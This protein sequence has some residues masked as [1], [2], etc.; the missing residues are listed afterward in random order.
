MFWAVWGAWGAMLFALLACIVIY[1]VELP[2]LDDWEMVPAL[3]GNE[4]HF[5]SWLWS[6]WA[7]HR[8]PL[9]RLI[10]FAL[11]KLSGGDFRAG[12]VFNTL[13]VATITA[14][15][16]LTARNIRGRASITDVFF[17]LLMMHLGHSYNLLWSWG[18]HYVS[19]VALTIVLLVVI[20]RQEGALRPWPAA[21]AVAAI[22]LLPLTGAVGLMMDAV[23]APW[24]LASARLGSRVRRAHEPL[25]PTVILWIAAVGAALEGVLYFVGYEAQEPWASGLSNPNV[26]S[27]SSTDANGSLP[28]LI[29]QTDTPSSNTNVMWW[30]S[31]LKP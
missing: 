15:M 2:I 17:P 6:Q 3:T 31:M 14:A 4:P 10:L 30:L 7:E 26:N 29:R 23:L 21:F 25:W 12:M 8:L 1:G 11:L 22:L 19:S 28:D 20:V 5:F 27:G 16:I 9:P 24:L 18:I 13:V